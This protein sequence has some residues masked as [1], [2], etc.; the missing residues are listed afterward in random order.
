MSFLSTLGAIGEGV[1]LGLQDVER[2]DEA[3]FN[4][5]QRKRKVKEQADDDA[6]QAELKGLRAPGRYKELVDGQEVERDYTDSQRFRDV[7]SIYS[8]FG[9]VK[10]SDQY[11]GL[12]NQ[13][14]DRAFQVKK[15]ENLAAAQKR[16]NDGMALLQKDPNEFFNQYGPMFNSNQFGG[17]DADNY[18][19]AQQSTP[20]GP[21][22]NVY[23]RD[24]FH[25]GQPA[26]Q[27]PMTSEAM[28][29]VL[30]DAYLAD[31]AA[32]DPEYMKLAFTKGQLGVSRDQVSESGRHN[33][34]TEGL[35]AEG[36]RL[37][38]LTLGE[39]IRHN[40]A[41]ENFNTSELNAKIAGKGYF[42]PGSTNQS[43]KANWRKLDD[44]TQ[45]VLGPDNQTP[46]F[47]ILSDGSKAPAN[48]TETSWLQIQDQ[49]K[50]AGVAAVMG[51]DAK[52]NPAVAY[53][54]RDGKYY[55]SIGEAAKAQGK[56]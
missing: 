18:I 2:Q 27:V 22:M 33:R 9:R 13:A 48:V 54:G 44:G 1:T 6:I 25:T 24:T 35:A 29:S 39:T 51:T 50:K 36:N 46:L 56:N 15:R 16:Y 12:A 7:A 55:T 23:R 47:N 30:Q 10:D 45:M 17:K 31:L 5:D 53:K 42:A 34:A 32:I 19:V 4:K 26:Y 37:Q 38:G 40:R 8:K 43:T 21:V 28:A 11:L 52:G 49:A 3:K 14:D 20:N 41:G